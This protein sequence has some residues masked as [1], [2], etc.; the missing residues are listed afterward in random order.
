MA[1]II[2]DFDGTFYR[3]PCA[4][5]PKLED[6]IDLSQL[7]LLEDKLKTLPETKRKEV[8]S[9]LNKKFKKLDKEQIGSNMH[10]QNAEQNGHKSPFLAS[11]ISKKNTTFSELLAILNAEKHKKKP[12]SKTRVFCA[13]ALA[14]MLQPEKE[15][16][17]RISGMLNLGLNITKEEIASYY[18]KY[19][20]I[21]YKNIIP[22]PMVI[23][24]IKQAQKNGDKLVVYTDNSKENI[25]N[26]LS[27]FGLKKED[28]VDVVDM[29]ACNSMTKKTQE[30]LDAFRTIME[31]H[32]I[33]LRDAKFYDD[34]PKI[35]QHIS[36][37]LRIP[38]YIVRENELELVKSPKKGNLYESISRQ[39]V[40][41]NR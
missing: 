2:V 24:V 22:N 19:A 21:K 11:K 25:I 39:S 40:Y 37:Y 16:N 29:F 35:C 3:T 23:N 36:Q 38:S 10:N 1:T 20:T 32:N 6:A 15:G 18:R 14:K 27:V 26:N 8:L 34:N 30:G 5:I 31:K 9:N 17:H 41:N 7:C 12:L 33:D 4:D 28:F 13:R